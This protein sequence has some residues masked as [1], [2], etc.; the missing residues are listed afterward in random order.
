[1]VVVDCGNKDSDTIH[2]KDNF[3]KGLENEAELDVT[4]EKK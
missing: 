2:S 4:A 1:M 3:S